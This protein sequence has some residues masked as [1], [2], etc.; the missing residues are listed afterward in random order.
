MTAAVLLI[1]T[2][3]FQWKAERKEEFIMLNPN[4]SPLDLQWC[5]Y[6]H[7]VESESAWDCFKLLTYFCIT[8]WLNIIPSSQDS[9]NVLLK[10]LFRTFI[11]SSFCFYR[12]QWIVGNYSEVQADSLEVHLRPLVDRMNCGFEQTSC[13]CAN[14]VCESAAP[15]IWIQPRRSEWYNVRGAE[16]RCYLF[17]WRNAT[18]VCTCMHATMCMNNNN[19][20]FHFYSAF[21]KPA[22]KSSKTSRLTRQR[23]EP[24]LFL[25]LTERTDGERLTV[26]H[27]TSLTY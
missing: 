11:M 3:F 23:H 7:H 13:E 5:V 9:S 4:V 19:N 14:K 20:K 6:C 27:N 21:H 12:W 25:S 1:G 26:A 2:L 22:N 15:N 16:A 17:K 10:S 24:S 8:M 18:T